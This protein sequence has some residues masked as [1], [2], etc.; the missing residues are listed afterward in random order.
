[1]SID[2]EIERI[3][4]FWSV[5]MIGEVLRFEFESSKGVSEVTVSSSMSERISKRFEEFEDHAVSLPKTHKEGKKMRP[6][7]SK[8]NAPRY[9]LAKWLVKEFNCLP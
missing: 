4:E 2:D 7:V 5:I 8:V 3:D 9:K 1:M 6:I